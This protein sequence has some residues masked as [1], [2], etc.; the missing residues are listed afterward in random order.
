VLYGRRRIEPS[1]LRRGKNTIELLYDTNHHGNE[2]LLP[3]P[4]IVLRTKRNQK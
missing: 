1:L 3:S 2:V 4:A